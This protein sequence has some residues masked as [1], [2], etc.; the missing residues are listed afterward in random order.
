MSTPPEETSAGPV[1]LLESAKTKYQLALARLRRGPPELA[2]LSL[3]GAVEDALRARG[4]RLQLPAAYEPFGQLLDALTAAPQLPLTPVEAEGVRRMHRLRARVAHGEQI[5]VTRETLE[6]YQRLAARLLPRYGAL[7]VGPEDEAAGQEAAGQASTTTTVVRRERDTVA[8]L[9]AEPALARRGDT[10]RIEREPPR[11]RT[12]YP[13]GTSAR[14]LGRARP[15][16]ATADLPLAREWSRGAQRGRGGADDGAWRRVEIW[17]RAQRWLLPAL[18]VVSIF[19]IGAL[20]SV[21]LQ[22]MRAAPPVPTAVVPTMSGAAATGAGA[23]AFAPPLPAATV[24]A[25]TGAPAPAAAQGPTAAPAGALAPGRTAFVRGDAVALNVRAR[26]GMAA[27][28][29]VL[30]SLAPGT[31][32][33][34]IGGPAEQDGFTWW[35][36]RGPTGEGWSAGQFLEVR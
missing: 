25:D 14:Y 27:D 9:A 12:V 23:T 1:E 24:A 29:P 3:H 35:Q 13:D 21:G 22:Q 30:F 10:A 34:V 19:L 31:A 20:I 7:V 6:A 18:A 4:L 5:S 28:N 11:E 15:S 16:R 8:A 26:P 33:G 17:G 32:V 36:V 2:L